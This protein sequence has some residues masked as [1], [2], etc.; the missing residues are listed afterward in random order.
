M[1]KTHLE[2]G[3]GA[4]RRL[5]EEHGNVLAVQALGHLARMDFFLETG[6]NLHGFENLFLAPVGEAK[7]ML[8]AIDHLLSLGHRAQS[9]KRKR[10]PFCDRPIYQTK[11]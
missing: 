6:G 2:G 1:K 9:K 11:V 5:F 3:D 7:E 4:Q 10:L 8:V